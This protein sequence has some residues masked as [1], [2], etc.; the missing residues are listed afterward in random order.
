MTMYA[1]LIA[2][3]D[4]AARDQVVEHARRWRTLGM[5]YEDWLAYVVQLTTFSRPRRS[6]IVGH[7]GDSAARVRRELSTIGKAVFYCR[8]VS[9]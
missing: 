1:T 5:H 6:R 7:L 8:A 2:T 4:Q 9:S 3:A